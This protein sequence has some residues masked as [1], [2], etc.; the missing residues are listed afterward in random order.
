MLK[1]SPHPAASEDRC[2]VSTHEW[3]AGLSFV[4]ASVH[5]LSAGE[6][7]TLSSDAQH[8]CALVLTQGALDVQINDEETVPLRGRQSVFDAEPPYVIYAPPNTRMALGAKAAS[9]V[10]WAS[11]VVEAAA[12]CGTVH[13]YGPED[14]RIEIRGE[15]VTERTVRHLLE[16]PG[17]AQR[18]RLVEVITPG[19]HWSSFPPHKHD[20]E[21]PSVESRLEELYY[22]HIEPPS[23]WAFQRIYDGGKLSE[24]L[25]VGDGDLVAVPRGYH[26]VSV[27]PGCGAYYLNVMAGLTRE[28]NFTVD[29]AFGHVPGF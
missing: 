10:V 26:P 6:V 28:W 24:P 4:S 12:A 3:D 11:A 17:Q 22:Y 21:N 25:C 18:L 9:E 8:E 27:P 20:T 14:M 1:R 23:L 19:G 13:V 7:L 15:G 29:P 2:V 5:W 16:E